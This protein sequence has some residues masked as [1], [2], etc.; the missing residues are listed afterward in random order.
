LLNRSAHLRPLCRL[1]RQFRG[2]LPFRSC[3]TRRFS[4]SALCAEISS[5]VVS[6]SVHGSQLAELGGSGAPQHSWLR[7]HRRTWLTRLTA[8]QLSR[9]TETPLSLSPAG[10]VIREIDVLGARPSNIC[11]GQGCHESVSGSATERPNRI[12]RTWMDQRRKRNTTPTMSLLRRVTQLPRLV[13][14]VPQHFPTA[15]RIACMRPTYSR[16]PQLYLG[17]FQYIVRSR[18]I[19]SFPTAPAE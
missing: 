2:D 18:A 16:L 7:S 5:Q 4:I 6:L 8:P 14:L 3:Q 9:L 1:V 15:R 12:G 10:D 11:F 13:R 17:D 19:R